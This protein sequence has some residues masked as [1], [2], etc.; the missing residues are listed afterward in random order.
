MSNLQYIIERSVV[1]KETGCWRW[2][3][4]KDKDGYGRAYHDGGSVG[5]HRLAFYLANGYWPKIACH[6]C[7]R[8]KFACVNPKHIYDGTAESNLEDRKK[9]DNQPRGSKSV[10]SKLKEKDIE[11]MF[12][13]KAEEFTHQQIADAFSVSKTT[14]TRILNKQT[15]KH[16]EID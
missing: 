7:G 15:W 4:F 5:A 1:E 3:L 6:S 2:T 16:V 14:V 11:E 12:E 8:G 10:R 9:H 13:M